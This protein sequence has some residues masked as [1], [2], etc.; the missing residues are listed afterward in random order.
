MVYDE[1][2][3]SVLISEGN[4]LLLQ[5]SEAIF[6]RGALFKEAIY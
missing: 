3:K 1:C 2:Y 6:L 4:R 5:E